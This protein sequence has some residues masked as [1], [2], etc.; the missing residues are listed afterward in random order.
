MAPPAGSQETAAAKKGADEADEADD[1]EIAISEQT[2][3][4]IAIAE[5]TPLQI[6]ISEQTPLNDFE[7]ASP[8]GERTVMRTAPAGR[9]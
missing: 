7:A 5:Q 2:P 8:H 4:Q 1:A 3:L 9:S 6:A